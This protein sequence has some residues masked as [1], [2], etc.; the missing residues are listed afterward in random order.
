MRC[1]A[2]LG[3]VPSCLDLLR[4][5]EGGLALLDKTVL[6][7]LEEKFRMGLFEH[8]FAMEGKALHNAFAAEPVGSLAASGAGSR[9]SCSKTTAYCR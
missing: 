1:H 4:R 3:T 8:P 9:W 5:T 6:A 7:V 2:L